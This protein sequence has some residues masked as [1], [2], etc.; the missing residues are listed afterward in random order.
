[1]IFIFDY[2]KIQTVRLSCADRVSGRLSPKDMA[3]LKDRTECAPKNLRKQTA[4]DLCS[5]V[6]LYT[7]RFGNQ[8]VTQI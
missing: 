2:F 4:N 8:R 1:M 6:D 5:V 7:D 3:V